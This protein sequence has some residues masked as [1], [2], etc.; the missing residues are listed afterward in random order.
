MP[1][2]GRRQTRHRGQPRVARSPRRRNSQ[3][4]SGTEHRRLE[5]VWPQLR[6]IWGPQHQ[7]QR[8][9]LGTMVAKADVGAHLQTPRSGRVTNSDVAADL[10][11]PATTG[12]AQR[13]PARRDHLRHRSPT[14]PAR[15]QTHPTHPAAARRWSRQPRRSLRRVFVEDFLPDDGRDAHGGQARERADPGQQARPEQAFKQRAVLHRS[16]FNQIAREGR[17]GRRVHRRSS[18]RSRS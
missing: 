18:R 15:P 8:G 1:G 7:L 6:P 11:A 12:L 3:R 14:I 10:P 5:D 13:S 16:P 4:A 9:A 17:S 2:S